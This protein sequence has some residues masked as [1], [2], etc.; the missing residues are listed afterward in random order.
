MTLDMNGN[1]VL[2]WGFKT[3]AVTGVLIGLYQ[4]YNVARIEWV[5]ENVQRM[6]SLI[7]YT[8]NVSEIIPN[9]ING[10]PIFIIALIL[11]VIIL[12]TWDWLNKVGL[13][14]EDEL[15]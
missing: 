4:A 1:P 8:T 14:R 12:R 13:P 9:L 3:C 5:I 15:H 11:S 10:I 6:P 7:A 2:P